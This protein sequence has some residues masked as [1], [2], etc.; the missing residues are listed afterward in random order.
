MRRF[1]TISI[2][3]IIVIAAIFA[4]NVYYLI[5]LYNSIKANV[6]RD[7]MAALADADIDDLL[8]R[9]GRAQGLASN[10]KVQ[11]DIEEY[12]AP[13]KA[14]A[15]TYRD[16]NGQLISVR[17]EADG[18]VTEERAALSEN[19]S[20]SNQMVDAMSRQFHVIMDKY[21]SYDMAV[22]DSV[23]RNQ[24]SNR[25]I[26]PDFLCVEVV[27]NKDSVI[28][29]NPKFKSESGLDSFRFNINP[30]E[31]I[32]YKAYMTPL[33]RHIISEMSGV[34]VTIFLLMVAF[35]MAFWYLFRT[36]SRLRTIE[37]MK[38]DFVSNMTHELK[39]PIAIAYSANDALLNY[40]T[41]NDPQ[42]KVTYLNIA[43]KQLKRLGELVENILAMSMERR[44]IMKLKPEEIQLHTFVDEIA[45][46]QRMRGDKNISINVNIDNG[47]MVEADRTHLAN[48]LN[49]LIDNAIKYSGDSVEITIVGDNKK[50]SVSDNGIGIPSK[51]IPYLF[52]KF[53]RVPHGNRQDVRGYG[54]GL[55]YVKSILDKME[56][57]I[58]VK[59]SEGEG[60]VFTIKFSKDEQ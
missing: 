25:F 31:G 16:K 2:T 41:A 45:A 49:N 13:R 27:N 28:C 34:I 4:C 48:V 24:L 60:S 54:I 53:Y 56:W 58:E 36:V 39:T 19:S 44:K 42:K 11:E 6:E 43:N 1:K 7:V 29:E 51:S 12:N 50:L 22:M 40:D 37:E 9:A 57:S 33:T 14:E 30:N 55:Y 20:Y 21:I 26:Y 5:S 18:T 15:S 17:T 52:N 35:T 47:I 59:S 23:L 46:A 32:Y 10:V 38:D 8:Y 3:F